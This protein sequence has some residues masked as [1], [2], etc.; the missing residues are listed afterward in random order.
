MA[1]KCN[2]G[3]VCV[4]FHASDN[5]VKTVPLIAQLCDKALG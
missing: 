3:L 1:L 2:C 5:N 4:L